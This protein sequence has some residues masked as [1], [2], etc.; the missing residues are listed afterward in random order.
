MKT[1]LLASQL[2]DELWSL[3]QAAMEHGGVAINDIKWGAFKQDVNVVDMLEGPMW[4]ISWKDD[5]RAIIRTKDTQ[6]AW[7]AGIEFASKG[8][9]PFAVVD[10]Y[11]WSSDL[12][13]TTTGKLVTTNELKVQLLDLTLAQSLQM[14]FEIRHL[15]DPSVYNKELTQE[16][17][18]TDQ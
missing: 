11:A 18:A 14:I 16:I 1:K 8:G 10:P 15:F 4:I 7:R 5:Y 13:K 2:T 9:N 17:E 12:T 6:T 3:L